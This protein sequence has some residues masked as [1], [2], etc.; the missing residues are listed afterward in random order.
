[1]NIKVSII[2]PSLNVEPYIEKCITS[3][4]EQTLQDIEIICVDAGSTDGTMEKIERYAR[5]DDRIHLIRSD[6]KSY[7]YQM[8]LGI[9]GAKGK[10]IGIVE[11]DDFV[12][13][14]MYSILY[15]IAEA[16]ELD[17]V[18]ANYCNFVSITEREFF[19]W[20][21]PLRESHQVYCNRIVCPRNIPE[22]YLAD[23]NVWSGIYKRDFLIRNDI[24]FC[25]SSGAAFQDIG[26]LQQTISC[27][28]KAWYSD[29][30]FYRYRA[31]RDDSSVK[32]PRGL[33]YART[34][35]ERLVSFPQIQKKIQNKHGFYTRM[36][37]VFLV[38]LKKLLP[39]ADFDTN[40]PCVRDDFEW[41]CDELK[42]N[43]QYSYMDSHKDEFEQIV[44]NIDD[45][46]GTFRQE[47][48]KKSDHRDRVLSV[49]KKNKTIIFGAGVRGGQLLNFML[50][51]KCKP[52]AICD[53]SQEKWTDPAVSL[54][55]LPLQKCMELYG[56]AF[57]IIANKKN[58]T[59]IK[60]QLEN[61]GVHKDNIA[62]LKW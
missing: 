45:Y 55:V 44:R 40:S 56:D 49:A 13:K 5:E 37:S 19:L 16:N 14:D 54:P 34:E 31:D 23:A 24:T 17:M 38:E 11:T 51:H 43:Y 57:Y 3:V 60:K 42:T 2:M 62:I 18:K 41:F 48:K 50:S 27:A 6:V 25:E 30:T 35:F 7:G 58:A 47:Y 36:L 4:L 52:V 29:K 46:I 28:T 8:N 59:D 39:L 32:S 61:E 12:A 10:Y 53:N 26:F 1:M 15:D 9:K 33:S 21:N 22:I 20:P